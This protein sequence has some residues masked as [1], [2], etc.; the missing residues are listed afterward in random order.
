MEMVK[1]IDLNSKDYTYAN[2]NILQIKR[3]IEQSEF[4]D[5]EY[6]SNELINIGLDILRIMCEIPFGDG[7]E[8]EFEWDLFFK[9][10]K[11]REGIIT[12]MGYLYRKSTA[13]NQLLNEILSTTNNEDLKELLE[14]DL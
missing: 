7:N 6:S 1:M 13:K 5:K 12:L 4:N 9:A 10:G 11:T 8:N 14:G 3:L 2:L